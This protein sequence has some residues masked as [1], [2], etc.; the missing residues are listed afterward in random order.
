MIIFDL[1]RL[2]HKVSICQHKTAYFNLF[3]PPFKL[4]IKYATQSHINNV[5]F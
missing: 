3:M 1:L 4:L 2:L 5:E